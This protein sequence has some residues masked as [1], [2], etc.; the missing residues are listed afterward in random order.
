MHSYFK[1]ISRV[2]MYILMLL[3]LAGFINALVSDLFIERIVYGA[4][5]P[6][7]ILILNLISNEE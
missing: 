5:L 1:T 3:A 2:L 7:Y 6:I 4:A